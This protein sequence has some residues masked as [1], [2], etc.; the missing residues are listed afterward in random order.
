MVCSSAMPLLCSKVSYHSMYKAQPL[1]PSMDSDGN[2]S[3]WPYIHIANAVCS[4]A[5]SGSMAT[6]LSAMV[7]SKLGGNRLD[8]SSRNLSTQN[9]TRKLTTANI[10]ISGIAAEYI[11][12]TNTVL[13]SCANRA[14]SMKSGLVNILR[15]SS[16]VATFCHLQRRIMRR[17]MSVTKATMCGEIALSSMVN[18]VPAPTFTYHSASKSVWSPSPAKL[19][20]K[21]ACTSSVSS[22]VFKN[23]RKNSLY[24]I[25]VCNALMEGGLSQRASRWRD[26]SSNAFT[27]TTTIAPSTTRA[28]D[29]TRFETYGAQIS[30]TSSLDS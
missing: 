13:R 8:R 18:T 22:P 3:G 26:E 29:D 19:H 28:E 24:M 2:T 9:T 6:A 27:I 10:N 11:R 17:K 12:V 30:I 1:S 20:P 5:A 21:F 14:D 16:S 25:D 4:N 7:W 23:S 15:R